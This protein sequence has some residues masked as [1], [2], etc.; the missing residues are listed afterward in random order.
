MVTIPNSQ[1]MKHLSSIRPKN[2]YD[3]IGNMK[4]ATVTIINSIFLNS[5]VNESVKR[6]YS[7]SRLVFTGTPGE[8]RLKVDPAL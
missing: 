6:H 7:E 4:Y 2:G 3:C 5:R 1:V 8:K